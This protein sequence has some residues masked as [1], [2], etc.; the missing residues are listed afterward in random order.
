MRYQ[1]PDLDR[2]TAFLNDFGMYAAER[3]ADKTCYR[4]YGKDQYV[5]YAQKGEKKFLGGTFEV[6]DMNELEKATRLE[7]A[8]Q[9]VGMSDAPGGGYMVTVHD[10]EGFPINLMYGQ[11]PA[12]TGTFPEKIIYNC[13]DDKP[14]VTYLIGKR[15]R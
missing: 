9:I 11:T 13:E 6:E 3:G 4:G 15:N 1:H 10:P 8:V 12:Q 7:G 2:I 14:R 5:Y